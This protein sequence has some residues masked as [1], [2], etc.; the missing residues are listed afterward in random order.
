MF[1]TCR[2]KNTIHLNMS[3]IQNNACKKVIRFSYE[4]YAMHMCNRSLRKISQKKISDEQ[5]L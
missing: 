1:D 2:M 4:I 5:I 3:G